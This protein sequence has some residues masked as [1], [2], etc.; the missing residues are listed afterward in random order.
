MHRKIGVILLAAGGSER[1]GQPKQLL[2][3]DGET[4]L[5]RAARAAWDTRL[6]PLVVVLGANFDACAEELRRILP[7]PE[8]ANG[9]P[10]WRLATNQNWQRGVGSSLR[11]GLQC[12]LEFAPRIDAVLFTLVDQPRV[13][14]DS[15]MRL[16]ESYDAAPDVP[17][18]ARYGDFGGVPAI[19]PATLFDELLCLPDERGAQSLLR[20]FAQRCSWSDMPEAALDIDTPADIDRLRDPPG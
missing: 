10:M 11:I 16:I 1:L 17:A 14:A 13:G 15:L 4:L 8:L 7:P 19:Y 3:L 18:A 5:A 20:R 6:R 2:S 9:A 12:L